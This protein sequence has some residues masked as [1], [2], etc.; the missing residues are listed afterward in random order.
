MP[1]HQYLN[2]QKKD[3]ILQTK[4]KNIVPP[5]IQPSKKIVIVS[6]AHHNKIEKDNHRF[7]NRIQ[8]NNAKKDSNLHK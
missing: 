7:G 8:G 6:Q 2:N 4:N 1:P 3:N 5:R